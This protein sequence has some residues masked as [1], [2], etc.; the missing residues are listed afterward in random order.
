MRQFGFTLKSNNFRAP[1]QPEQGD[2][3]LRRRLD[4]DVEELFDRACAQNELEKAADLLVLLENF[5][6][7]RSVAYGRERR[8]SNAA[9]ERARAKLK[10]LTAGRLGNA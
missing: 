4:D 9:V 8:L 10:R 7:R 3:I 2:R 1:A 5:H 6:A